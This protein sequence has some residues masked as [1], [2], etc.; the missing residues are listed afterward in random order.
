MKRTFITV[1]FL[2][3]TLFSFSQ[4]SSKEYNELIRKSRL[5]YMAKDYQ[6]AAITVSSAIRMSG[7]STPIEDMDRAAYSWS[8]AGNAD[9]SF[10]YLN[11]IADLEN[12]IFDNF[13]W[14]AEDEDFKSL[15]NDPRWKAVTDKL[16]DKARNTFYISRKTANGKAAIVQNYNAGFAW[17]THK[18]IDSANY[19]LNAAID[20]KDF[21]FED[22]YNIV[23]DDLFISLEKDKQ[24]PALSDKIF[25]KLNKKYISSNTFSNTAKSPKKL[26]IDGGHYN[27][28]DIEGTYATLAGT[29]RKSGF[30]V[31]GHKG[32]FDEASLRNTDML[33]ITNPHPDRIDSINQ[34]VRRSGEPPRWAAAATLSAYTEAEA[35]VIEKWV[36]NGGS[37]FLILDH[38]PFGQVGRLLTAVFGIENR[39]ASTYDPLSRDPAVDTTKAITTLFTRSKGLIGKHPIMN[40]VDSVTTYTG[41][42]LIGPPGSD[43]LLQLPSTASDLDW[44]AE[45]K[46]YRNRSAAGRS[47]AIAFNYG[48]GRVVML[49]EA[50]I[51]RPSFLSVE[52]R[53]NWKFILNILRWLAREKMD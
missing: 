22:A 30:E 11:M 49:G 44:V 16:F 27:L 25:S 28:H 51:T 32:K 20:S 38:A 21:T 2:I 52:D 26:V 14:V 45:T 13:R 29:L 33:I 37:F 48:K 8:L 36:K 18:N 43:V 12:L 35:S 3:G 19:Y 23:T 40:G 5:L 42:S 34:R 47:Q 15:H 24:S 17:I 53:G 50:A 41:E 6:N 7:D 4:V 9:S 10:F 31:S 39:F 1:S 46:Q